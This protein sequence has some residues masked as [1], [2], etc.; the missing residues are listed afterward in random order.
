[1]QL[2]WQVE[3]DPRAA[4]DPV[5]LSYETPIKFAQIGY[6]NA[7]LH[8]PLEFNILQPI[9]R[10]ALPSMAIPRRD[11]PERDDHIITLV[12][13][14]FRNL[15]EISARNAAA[16]GMDTERNE[17]SRSEAILAFDRSDIFPLLSALAAGATDE[18]EKVDCL[19]L[20]ILYHLFRGIRVEDVLSTAGEIRSVSACHALADAEKPFGDL[21]NMLRKEDLARRHNK[22]YTSTRHNRF[23]TMISVIKHNDLRLTVAGQTTLQKYQSHSLEKLDAA[24][25]YHKPNRH[26]E[27]VFSI[28][29][30]NIHVT[31]R[32]TWTS[33]LN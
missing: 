21:G 16:A 15:A 33:L 11:R 14:L 20:E 25:K 23:G 10:I 7:I 2:T 8:H 9:V 19:V 12:I 32:T 3:L 5:Q 27:A 28:R 22:R 24:K 4:E 6:K 1:V 13:S 26:S 29:L 31:L 30:A 17:Y 18:Y